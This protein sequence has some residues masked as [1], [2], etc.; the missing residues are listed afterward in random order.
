MSASTSETTVKEMTI[1]VDVVNE[2]SFPC[3][4]TWLEKHSKKYLI[5]LEIGKE[6]GKLHYQG[7]VS[8]DLGAKSRDT[9][10]KSLKDAVPR[11]KANQYSLTHVKKLDVWLAYICKQ[12]DIKLQVGYTDEEVAQFKEASF[13]PDTKNKKPAA[14]TYI[15]YMGEKLYRFTDLQGKK[16]YNVSREICIYHTLEW[17]KIN[18]KINDDY[19][20]ARF[21]HLAELTYAFDDDTYMKR[22]VDKI[23]SLMDRFK[24]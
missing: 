24:D 16:H 18:C 23:H 2:D 14:Q 3:M 17:F 20:V 9:W 15:E 13:D 22:R 11:T 19:I 8:L 6:T 5:A 4:K 12:G 10:A 21:V 1:R 7:I